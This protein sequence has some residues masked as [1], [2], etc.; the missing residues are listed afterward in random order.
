[1]DAEQRIPTETSFAAR[2]GLPIV[3]GLLT[4]IVTMAI[5]M[6]SLV[7]RLG[8]ARGGPAGMVLAS[9][10]SM[11]VILVCR[12]IGHVIHVMAKPGKLTPDNEI[13]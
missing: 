10:T 12:L 7:D 11:V 1:M 13:S 8:P 9:T 5:I 6:G 4:G 2:W 3:V